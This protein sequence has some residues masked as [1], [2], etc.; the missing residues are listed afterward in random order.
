M[1]EP[2]PFS[3]VLWSGIEDIYV[4]ILAHPFIGGLTDGTLD[5]EAF[6]F[7]VVQPLPARVRARSLRR[8]RRR[9]K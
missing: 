8:R 2:R 6:R 1:T 3:Q 9:A 5:R 4:A 7:Y